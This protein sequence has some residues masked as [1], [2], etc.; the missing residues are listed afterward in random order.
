MISEKVISC[1]NNNKNEPFF[2]DFH[3]DHPLQKLASSNDILHCYSVANS[4]IHHI[5]KNLQKN[6]Q[7]I[8]KNNNI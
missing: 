5:S 3:C 6:Y 4:H 7:N 1:N 8:F 2:L